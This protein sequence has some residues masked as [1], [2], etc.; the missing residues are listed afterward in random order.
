MV[1]KLSIFKSDWSD[2]FCSLRN[3]MI[4]LHLAATTLLK[5]PRI[6]RC[7]NHLSFS[8]K[9]ARA[10]FPA[11]ICNYVTKSHQERP[12][13]DTASESFDPQQQKILCKALQHVNELGY[14]INNIAFVR[15]FYNAQ[16]I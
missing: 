11:G 13:T 5:N 7:S 8:T 2:P 4:R 16:L 12:H 1:A 15:I 6:S 10:E 14:S 9:K 3:Q